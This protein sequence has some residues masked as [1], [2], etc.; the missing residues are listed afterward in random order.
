MALH[1]ESY[2]LIVPLEKSTEF[3]DIAFLIL[4][5]F[6]FGVFVGD[7]IGP[8]L[9]RADPGLESMT[10]PGLD[11]I[12]LARDIARGSS[13]WFCSTTLIITVVQYKAIGS[14]NEKFNLNY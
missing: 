13:T 12:M 7:T 1:L 11:M 5:L 3:I 4:P 6:L 10:D 14:R 9:E 2:F 8:K